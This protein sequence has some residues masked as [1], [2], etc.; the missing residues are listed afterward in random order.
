MAKKKLIDRI[1]GRNG[2]SEV[3]EV[4]L[5]DQVRAAAE[6]RRRAAENVKYQAEADAIESAREALK[7]A[8]AA[9]KETAPAVKDTQA[10]YEDFLAKVD[11]A[12]NRRAEYVQGKPSER[13][14]REHGGDI[15]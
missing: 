10:K 14:V 5:I 6:A 13:A 3:K 12:E 9:E 15:F 7:V 4:K 2:G 1:S 11:E 8:E